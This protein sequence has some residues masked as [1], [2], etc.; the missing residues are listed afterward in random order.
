MALMKCG[1]EFSTPLSSTRVSGPIFVWPG[2]EDERN[3]T[4]DPEIHLPKLTT[5]GSPAETVDAVDITLAAA[6]IV[7]IVAMVSSFMSIA[8]Q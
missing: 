1:P 5:P 4:C 6:V 7:A 3:W 2:A 8:F